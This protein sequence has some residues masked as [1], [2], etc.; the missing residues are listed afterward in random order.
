M[1]APISTIVPSSTCGSSASCWLLLNRC[2]SSMKTTV[3][4]PAWRS[5]LRV[6]DERPDVGDAAGHGGDRAPVSRRAIGEQPGEGRLARA[7]RSP[8]HHA[9]GVAGLAP[10]GSGRHRARPGG[11]AP[12]TRPGC[13]PHPGRE[14]RAGLR[15]VGEERL[16]D[17]RRLTRHRSAPSAD[18]DARHGSEPARPRAR[19]RSRSRS[20]RRSRRR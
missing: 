17:A 6:R 3:R 8:Q 12:R 14:R 9:R 19:R 10:P 16:G 15:R 11:P 13:G 7:G 2:S 4:P 1:V 5:A 20:A 18:Y